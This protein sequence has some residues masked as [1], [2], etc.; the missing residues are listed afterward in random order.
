[1]EFQ[2]ACNLY[3]SDQNRIRNRKGMHR[4]RDGLGV[5]ERRFLEAIWWSAFGHFRH[6]FLEYEVRDF[7]EGTRYLDFAYIRGHFKAC[8][9]ID[10]YEPHCRNASR[11]QFTDNLR[12]QNDLIIDGWKI[13][14]FSYD[15]IV[16]NPRICQRTI[17]QL[18]GRWLGEGSNPL[19]LTPEEKEIIRYAARTT[20]I[21][22]PFEIKDLIDVSSKYARKILHH[23]VERDILKPI[24]GRERIRGYEL[25]MDMGNLL[26]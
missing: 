13:I 3:M 2:E 6:L 21:I 18:L 17:Q 16:H 4:L 19:R 26:L 23:M 5:S 7:K 11:G 12:R 9:E 22:T 8:F 20:G 14:R 24:G 15:D 25:M 10:G 1:M